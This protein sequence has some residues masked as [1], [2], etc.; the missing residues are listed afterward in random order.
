MFLL[1]LTPSKGPFSL[2]IKAKV[3]PSPDWPVG[4]AL[5]LGPTPALTHW[6]PGQLAFWMLPELSRHVETSGPLH[7]LLPLPG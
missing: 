3:F 5:E 7:L 1:C 4:P 6:V 2:P